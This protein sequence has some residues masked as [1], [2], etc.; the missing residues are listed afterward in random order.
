MYRIFPQYGLGKGFKDK[1][2][3]THVT[4]YHNQR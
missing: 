3:R 2:E 1:S 4:W